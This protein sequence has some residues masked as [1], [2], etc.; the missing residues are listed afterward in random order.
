MKVIKGMRRLCSCR[1]LCHT[2]SVDTF[3]H[4]VFQIDDIDRSISSIS[5]NWNR[6]WIVQFL[7][8]TAILEFTAYCIV[9]SLH[10]CAIKFTMHRLGPR[11]SL[12]TSAYYCMH[13]DILHD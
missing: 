1:V 8:H 9:Q 4:Q 11:P 12:T 13:H 10:A 6:S 3:L 5:F 2:S 7:A